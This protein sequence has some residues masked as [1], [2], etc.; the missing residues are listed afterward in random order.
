V[1]RIVPVVVLRTSWLHRYG[2]AV[3][4]YNMLAWWR[5]RTEHERVEWCNVVHEHGPITPEMAKVVGSHRS[6]GTP[7]GAWLIAILDS[8]APVT[9]SEQTW[10]MSR[11]FEAFIREQCR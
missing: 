9:A 7:G 5:Q 8:S 6:G 10:I 2:Q 3:A 11:R 1:Y 4:Y